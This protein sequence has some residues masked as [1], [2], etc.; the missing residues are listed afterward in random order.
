[1]HSFSV[2]SRSVKQPV[3][4]FVITAWPVVPAG[5]IRCLVCVWTRSNR[6]K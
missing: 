3:F 2:T 1:M 5:D 6:R 4:E